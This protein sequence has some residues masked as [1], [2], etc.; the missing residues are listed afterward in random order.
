VG[1]RNLSPE[2]ETLA[3]PVVGQGL[4]HDHNRRTRGVLVAGSPLSTYA[5]AQPKA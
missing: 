5:C 4:L 2:V 3:G 1:H